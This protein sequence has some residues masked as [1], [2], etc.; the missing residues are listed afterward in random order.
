MA[1]GITCLKSSCVARAERY[2]VHVEEFIAPGCASTIVGR[3]SFRLFKEQV[4]SAL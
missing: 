2:E 4:N 3:T 1:V